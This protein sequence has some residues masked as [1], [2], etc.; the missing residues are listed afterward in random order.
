MYKI[1][2][3]PVVADA[4]AWPGNP[5][6]ETEPMSLIREGASFNTYNI[7]LFNHFGSHMDA[8]RHISDQ[9]PSIT[10]VPLDRFIYEKPL[11]LDISKSFKES[12]TAEDLLPYA[13]QI[14]K[15]DLLLLRSGF[16]ACRVT[17]P[18]RYSYEGPAVGSDACKYLV[19]QFPN[20]RGIAVDW[21]SL[22][23]YSNDD[24]KLAHTYLLCAYEHYLC[25]IE[26]IDLSGLEAGRI[27]RVFSVPLLVPGIDSAPVTVIA[28]LA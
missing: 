12:V 13:E 23:S 28:E 21:V 9:G 7:K 4:P 3:Y 2:S 18:V 27:K 24:G 20:L 26:D 10:E 19:E 8:P 6:P 16:S 5:A 11:L 25:I 15:A 14:Q 1:L 22:A 17:D